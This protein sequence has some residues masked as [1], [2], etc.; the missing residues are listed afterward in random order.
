M[1][2]KNPMYLTLSILHHYSP[3]NDGGSIKHSG[4]TPGSQGRPGIY[5]H[6]FSMYWQRL[7]HALYRTCCI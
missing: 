7:H 1:W 6:G 5:S 4:N 3:G 2:G